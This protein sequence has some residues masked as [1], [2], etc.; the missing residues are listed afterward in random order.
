MRYKQ[1]PGEAFRMGAELTLGLC[2][3]LLLLVMSCNKPANV[4]HLPTKP[5][6][7][8][9]ETA[10]LLRAIDEFASEGR[11]SRYYG[12]HTFSGECIGFMV[13]TNGLSKP[14]VEA[15]QEELNAVVEPI[16]KRKH[17]E[18]KTR[19]QE[20]LCGSEYVE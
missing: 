2:L 16:L 13:H 14:E 17:K 18:L 19:L 12:V 20:Q 9:S 5:E 15:F 6:L 1:Q 4:N 8:Y 3:L 7:G 11:V 10:Q